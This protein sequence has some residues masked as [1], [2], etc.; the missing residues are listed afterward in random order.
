MLHVGYLPATVEEVFFPDAE[1]VGDVGPSLALLA[2]RVEGK[3]TN[4]GAL[5]PLHEGILVHI[6]ERA[7]E[8]RFPLTPQRIVHDVRQV[9]PED[10]IVSLETCKS[11]AC[12]R[13][14]SHAIIARTW[15]TRF[16]STTHW[17]RWAPACRRRRSRGCLNSKRPNSASA[18]STHA[19]IGI[20][21]CQVISADLRRKRY[22]MH[23]FWHS[24]I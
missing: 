2:D 15:Q 5:L 11:T 20:C 4:A 22:R 8:N 16:C 14:G 18:A 21:F 13:S 1:V 7:E 9:M 10:G 3:L 19:R 24:R 6:A 23:R 12:T 17:Q